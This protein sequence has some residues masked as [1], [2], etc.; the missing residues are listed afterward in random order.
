[1]KFWDSVTKSLELKIGRQMFWL[2]LFAFWVT[3]FNFPDKLIR[4]VPQTT[5][6]EWKTNLRLIID[7][8]LRQSDQM[9]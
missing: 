1:M 3:K 7:F 2:R 6:F 9:T 4:N 5:G 8:D